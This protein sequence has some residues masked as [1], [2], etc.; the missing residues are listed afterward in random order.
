MQTYTANDAKTHFGQLL[1]I[2]QREPVQVTK[3]NRVVSVMISAQDYQAMQAFYA[4]RLLHTIDDIATTAENI[5]LTP[6]T[7]DLLLADES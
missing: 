2:A 3:H 7:L 5:G 1:D 6:E 4:N